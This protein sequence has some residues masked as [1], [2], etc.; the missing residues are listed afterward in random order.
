M[1]HLMDNNT[2]IFSPSLSYF[3][4]IPTF[5]RSRNKTCDHWKNSLRHL[6]V[7]FCKKKSENF[8]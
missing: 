4:R 1:M 2:V 8:M 7:D 5:S 3:C 6:E